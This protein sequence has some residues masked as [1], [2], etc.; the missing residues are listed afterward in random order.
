M[1]SNLSIHSLVRKWNVR[2]L[3]DDERGE[4]TCLLASLLCESLNRGNSQWR[5]SFHSANMARIILA[6]IRDSIR[7]DISL[8][9]PGGSFF[10]QY[11]Y[12]CEEFGAL[13][14][15]QRQFKE[16]QDAYE[17]ASQCSAL[18]QE[19]DQ[20]GSRSHLRLIKEYGSACWRNGDIE[21]AKE[22]FESMYRES[23]KIYGLEDDLTITASGL[24]KK[25]NDKLNS[26]MSHERTAY[27]ALTGPKS[28]PPGPGRESSTASSTN[29]QTAQTLDEVTD[30]V[31]EL[32]FSNEL[33]SEIVE[34]AKENFQ[35]DMHSLNGFTSFVATS[36]YYMS[37]GNF[38]DQ[39]I[40]AERAWSLE[41]LPWPSMEG[42]CQALDTHMDRLLPYR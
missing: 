6:T 20:Q 8:V 42:F 30:D 22:L 32:K 28:S 7:D 10:D 35:F 21:K 37:I 29:R 2:R 36:H 4:L 34:I 26:S 3:G 16:A 1:H 27:T 38:R 17:I 15:D 33:S 25:V 41:G 18:I 31:E 19:P 14:T 24:L 39:E 12:V 5:M 13:F 40:W 23:L 11:K 9:I